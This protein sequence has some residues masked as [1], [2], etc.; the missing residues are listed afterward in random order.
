MGCI[1][2]GN[3]ADI[4]YSGSTQFFGPLKFVAVVTIGFPFQLG[5]VISGIRH[6]SLHHQD[7]PF[8]I[9][10]FVVIVIQFGR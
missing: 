5:T 3:F 7:S 4:Q 6:T 2:I 1:W 10:I 8:D 9:D